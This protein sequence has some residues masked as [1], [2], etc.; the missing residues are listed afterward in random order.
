MRC[1]TDTTNWL[2]YSPSGYLAHLRG[3]VLPRPNRYP[4][5]ALQVERC[6]L[7]CSDQQRP[8]RDG[9]QNPYWLYHILVSRRRSEV[10]T[11]WLR[12]DEPLEGSETG[13]LWFLVTNVKRF[14]GALVERNGYDATPDTFQRFIKSCSGRGPVPWIRSTHTG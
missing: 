13:H 6:S 1:T 5:F 10:Y 12:K 14:C 11:N 4:T 8:C 3:L 7:P 9:T 2:R